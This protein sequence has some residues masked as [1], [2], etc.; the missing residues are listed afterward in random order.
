MDNSEIISLTKG[1]NRRQASFSEVCRWIVDVWKE[2]TPET[3]K[4]GFKKAGIESYVSSVEIGPLENL[5]TDPNMS[6]DSESSSEKDYS[7]TVVHMEID[8]ESD[9]ELVGDLFDGFQELTLA[10]D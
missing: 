3:I 6:S 5:Q 10:E 2:V 4:N 8:E 1:G 9:D 7:D